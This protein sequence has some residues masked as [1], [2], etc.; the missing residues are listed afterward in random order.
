MTNS[1]S[2]NAYITL[3]TR[4]SYL[5]GALLL[6]H[7]LHTHSPT[8]PLII[9]YTPETLPEPCIEAFRKEAQYSNILLH[10]V[11]HLRLPDDGSAHGMVAERF[12][13]T[14][15]K[16]RV[17]EVYDAEGEVG[18]FERL[19]WLDADMM[20][21]SN[22]SPLVFNEKNDEYLMGGDALR[23]MATHVCCC[24]LDHD[25][26]APDTWT[27]QNCALTHLTSPSQIPDVKS[28]PQTMAD[29]NSGT[30]LY[31][32]SR[33]LSEFVT[34]QFNDLGNAK[35]RAMKFPDQ[36]FLNAAF[37]G[38]WASLSWRANALK[39]WRYWHTNIWRDDQVA[40]LHYIVDKPWAA[41]VKGDGTAGYL[42]KDG[43]THGWWWDAYNRWYTEREAQGETDL[44]GV[45]G[46]YVAGEKGEMDDEMRAV[47][48]G[49]QDFAKKWVGGKEVEAESKTQTQQTD[50]EGKGKEKEKVD[51]IDSNPDAPIFHKRGLGERGH[52][53]VV[54]GGGG[55]RGGLRGRGRGEGWCV[56]QD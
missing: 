9:T 41:R 17:F 21:F 56:M 23:M 11:E 14:W 6:A 19:C 5:A 12:V 30:F 40:V 34:Q 48:G 50:E 27:P 33:A 54:R 15:T 47:G 42:G 20:V 13:D 36:D 38:R 7:T 51:A 53:P 8:T 55:L 32:P 1:T 3:L 35:L 25:S 43:A 24:N 52:G 28:E 18:G 4:P 2:K 16:L 31:R 46:R 22:P 39:T 49:A 45:V 37:A 10:A 44:L 29:F 26:W